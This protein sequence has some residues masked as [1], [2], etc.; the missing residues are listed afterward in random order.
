MQRKK[1]PTFYTMVGGNDIRVNLSLSYK[2]TA[3]FQ[4]Y[5]EGSN[6]IVLDRYPNAGHWIRI[7]SSLNEDVVIALK[8]KL[9]VIFN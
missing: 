5:Q 8:R 7:T 6:H 2:L 3:V 1:Y 4:G 9:K